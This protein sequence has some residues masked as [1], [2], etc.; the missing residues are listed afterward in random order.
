[1]LALDGRGTLVL[2][3]VLV[4]VLEDGTVEVDVLGPGGGSGTEPF[5]HVPNE[6][7]HPTPQYSMPLPHQ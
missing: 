2:V 7:L 5:P 1:M 6:P 4:L 3:L